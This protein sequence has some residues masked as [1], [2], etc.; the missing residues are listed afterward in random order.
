MLIKRKRIRLQEHG[1][2]A[3][4]RYEI[5]IMHIRSQIQNSIVHLFA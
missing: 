4:I 1:R 5:G 3:V 2:L